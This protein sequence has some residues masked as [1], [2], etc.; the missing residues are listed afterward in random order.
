MLMRECFKLFASPITVVVFMLILLI[1]NS[2]S[3]QSFKAEIPSYVYISEMTLETEVS[4]GSGS[5][6]ITD[7]WVTMNGEFLGVFELPAT[8]PVLAQGPQD[9]TIYPGV[10]ANGISATRIRNPF[11]EVCDL[12]SN[13]LTGGLLDSNQIH[14]YKDS[15]VSV[16]AKTHYSPNTEFLMIEDYEGNELAMKVSDYSDT[17]FVVGSPGAFFEDE[18]ACAVVYLDKANSF[19]EMHSSEMISLD[20]LYSPTM[21]ELNYQCDQPFEVGVLI[22]SS[23]S[24]LLRRFESL[25]VNPSADWNKIYV[26]M[27]NQ[28]VLGNSS[29]QYGVYI[30]ALKSDSSET[31]SFYFDNIKWLHIK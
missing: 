28:V 12:Y 8:V 7:A 25:R 11:L 19:F 22:K 18:N 17:N 16:S 23:S 24:E 3:K 30:N 26:H 27:T 14:L 21:L 6:K 2:C 10:K 31:A 15:M 13:D 9:F 5:N 4:E 20:K 1:V 29:D